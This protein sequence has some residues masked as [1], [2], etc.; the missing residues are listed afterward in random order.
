MAGYIICQYVF[1]ALSY[2]LILM[3]VIFPTVIVCYCNHGGA[4]YYVFTHSQVTCFHR[5]AVLKASSSAYGFVI[6]NSFQQ[7]QPI[8][9]VIIR[10][11]FEVC[12]EGFLQ[13]W[14]FPFDGGGAPSYHQ[15]SPK[16]IGEDKAVGVAK[17]VSPQSHICMWENYDPERLSLV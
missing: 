11:M 7:Y 1:Q 17:G 9:A 16:C 10:C 15:L 4:V 6:N 3:F 2:C 14:G 12:C 13:K 5:I 8:L